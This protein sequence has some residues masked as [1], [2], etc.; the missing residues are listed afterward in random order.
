MS[1][2]LESQLFLK[3]LLNKER[4]VMRIDH[5]KL[6]QLQFVPLPWQM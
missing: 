6:A 4:K 3:A 5:V 2:L 1:V